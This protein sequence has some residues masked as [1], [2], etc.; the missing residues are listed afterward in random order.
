MDPLV[1][2]HE[3][4]TVQKHV[5][6]TVAKPTALP[7]QLIESLGED[8]IVPVLRPIANR[9]SM[10]PDQPAGTALGHPKALVQETHHFSTRRGP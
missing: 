4:L 3:A 2:H 5:Q 1:V 9:G 7:R 6:S 8:I 10:D